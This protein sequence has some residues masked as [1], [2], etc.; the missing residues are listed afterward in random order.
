LA[1][2]EPRSNL[3]RRIETMT[4]PTAFPSKLRL[5]VVLGLATTAAA[6]A[7]FYPDPD[8]GGLTGVDLEATPEADAAIVAGP[9]FTPF[10]VRPDLKNIPDVRRSLEAEY[11]P[12]LREAGIGGQVNVWFLIGRQGEVVE[13]RVQ[14]SSGHPALDAAALRVAAEME[15]TPALNRDER[16]MVWVAFPITFATNA[17]P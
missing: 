2:T 17:A 10:T 3:E 6:L 14:K 8:G 15:F 7:C 4:R 11:P 12:L 5:T 13:T 16:V 1:L 9:T